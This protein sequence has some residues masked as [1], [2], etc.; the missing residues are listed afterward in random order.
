MYLV[1]ADASGRGYG[2]R[3]CSSRYSLMTRRPIAI[4]A[5]GRAGAPAMGQAARASSRTERRAPV[6]ET[7]EDV[8]GDGG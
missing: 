3:R 4:G 1:L 6:L 8:E 7:G 2:C 5:Y